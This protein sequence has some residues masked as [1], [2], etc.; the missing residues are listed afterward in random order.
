[1]IRWWEFRRLHFNLIVGTTGLV[2]LVAMFLT[3]VVAETL[4]Q[5]PIGWPDGMGIILIP[6]GVVGY[7]VGANLCYTAG[8]AVELMLRNWSV[9]K[10]SRFAVFSFYAGMLFSLVLTLLPAIFTI[11]TAALTIHGRLTGKIPPP[12]EPYT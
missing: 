4:I 2:T 5:E 1:M 6:V 8:W 11:V 3:A 9:S 12:E 7:G 10:A